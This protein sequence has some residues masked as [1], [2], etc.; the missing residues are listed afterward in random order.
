MGTIRPMTVGQQLRCAFVD[1]PRGILRL[2]ARGRR[3]AALYVGLAVA[4]LGGLG[5]AVLALEGGARRVLLSWLFP[6]ELH[7]PADFFVGYVFKS[8]TR[9]VLANA[10]VGV[11]LLVVSLVLF[12]V[13]ERLSQ[14]V[15]RDAD[16][17]GGR[18]LREL[19]WWQ[20]GL[21]EVKLTLL[22]I[23]AFF[24]IFWL[25]H[26]PAPWRKIAST[27]LSYLLIFFS[28][29]VDFGAPLPMRHGLRYSQI[30]KAM[31]RRPL[32]T[33]AF[34]AVFSAPVIVAA[35]VVAHV[36]DLGAGA[37]VGVVFGAN[38]VSIA[39]AAVG[40]TWFGA[41]LLP[42]VETQERS[43]WPT[44]VAAWVALL[45]VVGVGTYAAGNLVVAL[46][47]K[48]QIL[49]CRYSPDWATLKVDKPALGALLGGQVRTQVSFDVVIEN[50][51]RLP[52]RLE[53]NDL[54]IADGDGIVIARGRLL[55]L[56]V[57]AGATVRTTVGLAVV[58]EARALLA[59]ASLNPANWRVT[60]LVH[61][62]GFD[63]PI[64]LKSG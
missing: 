31:L 40:G 6:A 23:A 46:Q 17:T 39:W 29:A 45:T 16:L 3:L 56:E 49:K 20:E 42:T 24:V 12:R 33:F 61:L 1:A 10:L 32:V 35:Q 52:V 41:R 11:T 53:D 13:K 26:D 25:G 62:D 21:E 54:V 36:P 37:T 8:Q 44:R 43:W 50:P 55:P 5:V 48:S 28:Y 9:Q 27:G 2:S 18:E 4:L 59:G 60:L 58:L 14:A 19:R 7:A 51:N 64:Y 22:Y 34:G 63:Y 15:E 47:G 30:V 57:P 38:V